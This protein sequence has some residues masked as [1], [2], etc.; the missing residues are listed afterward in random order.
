MR[1]LV[2]GGLAFILLLTVPSLSDDLKKKCYH[3]HYD[4]HGHVVVI[5]VFHDLHHPHVISG[6]Q[7]IFLGAV[8]DH[9]RWRHHGGHYVDFHSTHRIH[10]FPAVKT[11]GT[12]THKK[13]TH[14]KGHIKRHIR[15]IHRG[16][17]TH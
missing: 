8:L 12:G 5:E 13:S 10:G 3:Y 6:I 16:I 17:H 2:I 9:H 1:K 4:D 14:K 11:H 7:H 15:K